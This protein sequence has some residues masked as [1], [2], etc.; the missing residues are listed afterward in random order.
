MKRSGPLAGVRVPE[1]ET[2][3]PVPWAGMMLADLGADVL[4]IDRPAPPD[5]GVSRDTRFEITGR[6]RRSLVTDLKRPE[7]VEQVLQLAARADVL[8]E[9]MRPGV[10]E[11]LSIGPDACLARHPALVYGCMTGWGQ[12]G[13]MA[14]DVGHDINYIATAGVLG[15]IGPASGPPAVPLNLVGDFGGGGMLL[16][17]GVL[18]AFLEARTSGRGQVVDA[19]MVD[20]ALAQLAPVIGRF[21]SG[22]CREDRESNLLDGGAPF[23][24]TYATADGKAVA[25][26]AIEPRFYAALVDGLGL[27][28]QTLPAHHDRNAWPA[29]RERFTALFARE[30]RSHW[31]ERF[32]GTEAC[33]SP[34]LS[35]GELAQH[36][37]LGARGSLVDN[38]GVLQP[39]PAPRFSR[40]P[41][42][43]SA[44]PA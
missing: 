15:T 11:R 14:Q 9:G 4:R 21:Q 44:A 40:T 27:T 20:G 13:P 42:A 30:T 23:Y 33:I 22:D 38:D 18:A 37:H 8:I 19:A 16:A 12:T 6:R 26:G 32:A 7:G 34:V 3:G 39:A 10:A 36:P 5:L 2:I 1:I 29:M 31:C 25:V 41:G 24:R 28:A 17:F 43:I 35:L